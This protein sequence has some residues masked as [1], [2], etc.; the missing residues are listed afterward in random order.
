MDYVGAYS[1]L[2]GALPPQLPLYPLG[3]LEEAAQ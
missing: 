1:A 2:S 3:L